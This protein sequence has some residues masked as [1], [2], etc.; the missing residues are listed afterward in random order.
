MPGLTAGQGTAAGVAAWADVWGWGASGKGGAGLEAP[1]W[2]AQAGITGSRAAASSNRRARELVRA[3]AGFHPPAKH[4]LSMSSFKALCK[5]RALI[6]RALQESDA[7][8]AEMVKHENTEE[9]LLHRRGNRL[10]Y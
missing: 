3:N 10:A 7:I 2:P 5:E 6:H 4:T 8:L 1:V 9:R